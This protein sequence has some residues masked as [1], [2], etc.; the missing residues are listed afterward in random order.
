MAAGKPK[1]KYPFQEIKNKK[2]TYLINNW[3]LENNTTWSDQGN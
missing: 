3:N 2:G 1:F